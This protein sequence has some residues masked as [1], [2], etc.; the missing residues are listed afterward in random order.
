MQIRASQHEI[1]ASVLLQFL[2]LPLYVEVLSLFLHLI[3][4]AETMRVVKLFSLTPRTSFLFSNFFARDLC[5][6]V[7]FRRHSLRPEGNLL[8]CEILFLFFSLFNFSSRWQRF[9]IFVRSAAVFNI[10][11]FALTLIPSFSVPLH[12]SAWILH[13]FLFYC[14]PIFSM[15]ILNVLSSWEYSWE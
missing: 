3:Y 15:H 6:L 9:R 4:T 12:F 7:D 5:L 11:F 2:H 10:I 1:A 13:E 14:L 8:F